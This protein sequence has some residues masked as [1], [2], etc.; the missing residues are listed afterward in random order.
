MDSLGD[1][2]FAE[3]ADLLLIEESLEPLDIGNVNVNE[4]LTETVALDN[5]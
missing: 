2:N 5:E 1:A 3:T 4:G